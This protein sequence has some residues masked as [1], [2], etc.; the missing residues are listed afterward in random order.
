MDHN[1]KPNSRDD[2]NPDDIESDSPSSDD[3][4]EEEE[5]GKSLPATH[6]LQ[7]TPHSILHSNSA[8]SASQP[9]HSLHHLL[10]RDTTRRVGQ[11]TSQP[12]LFTNRN[13]GPPPRNRQREQVLLKKFEDEV[14]NHELATKTFKVLRQETQEKYLYQ[15][16][17]YICHCANKGLDNFYVDYLLVKELIENEIEKRGQITENTIKSL[18]SSLN[19]LYH[20]NR[21]AYS[22]AQPHIILGDNIVQEIMSNYK[23]QTQ[24]DGNRG[25][26]EGSSSSSS[27]P[28]NSRSTTLKELSD[29]SNLSGKPAGIS[30]ASTSDSIIESR[31]QVDFDKKRG[32]D[33]QEDGEQEQ[34]PDTVGDGRIAVFK[35][36]T[37]SKIKLSPQEEFLLKKFNQEVLESNNTADILSSLTVNTFK[38]YA[39]DMKRYIRFCAR[40][41][42]TNTFIDEEI[43]KKFLASEVDKSKK[44]NSKKL[45]TSLLKLHQ[46]NC[47]A[48]N[49]D[50]SEGDIVFLIN[51]YVDGSAT[52]FP[53]NS[54]FPV[55]QFNSTNLLARLDEMLETTNQLRGLT[56]ANK[57]LH[58]NEF[59][60]YASF[61]S[62][63]NLNH[64]HVNGETIV[65]YFDELT[66]SDPAINSKKLRRFMRKLSLLHTL[67]SEHFENYPPS[68]ENVHLVEEFITNLKT[69]RGITQPISSS[70]D[71][72]SSGDVAGASTYSGVSSSMSSLA[73]NVP[74]LFLNEQGGAISR[75]C[76]S[77]SLPSEQPSGATGESTQTNVGLG[78]QA[79]PIRAR[80]GALPVSAILQP[81]PVPVYEHV[82]QRANVITEKD[83]GDADADADADE[84][85]EDHGQHHQRGHSD[86]ADEEEDSSVES[87]AIGGSTDPDVEESGSVSD[88]EVD[89]SGSKDEDSSDVSIYNSKRQKL[90]SLPPTTD[91]IPPFVMNSDIS[92]V[93]QL[94]EEWSLIVKRTRKW[95]LGWIK[96]QVDYQIY[97]DRK[98]IV[99]FIE[100]ILPE[101]DE[102][103]R[104]KAI[105]EIDEDQIYDIAKVFD[106]YIT[107][108]EITLDDLIR[109]IDSNPV[110]SKKE[111]LRILART[112]TT[113]A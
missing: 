17:R 74:P 79:N 76:T 93:T 70:T 71:P 60:R 46:L 18:R 24:K 15:I 33:E 38:S 3:L 84:S 103:H 30:S 90:E 23:E 37:S 21:I 104:G 39:T 50:Y 80:T 25:S 100:D 73:A 19:K 86:D 89:D 11:E 41:G 29:A 12:L 99:D 27:T 53:D 96:T 77:S 107:R 4:I 58:K 40:Q 43:L 81:D 45:R 28:L 26:G 68:V 62:K 56:E 14:L 9:L 47:Q 85:E 78:E 97:S 105:H 112:Q 110:Y 61:C 44:S 57:I 22:E 95:G 75:A 5:L 113:E 67:N 64:F 32:D 72:S 101:L 34:S 10:Q 13:S 82:G 2:L 51:K 36:S 102:Q 63:N 1:E 87:N 88:D 55:E 65:Q 35:L 20:M 109:K 16:R 111:F 66:K 48:Y 7:G 83:S 108:R 92:T 94:V 49:L 106:Q 42:R 69:S 59:K 31:E 54:S 91:I 8:F 98:I 52:E 6:V